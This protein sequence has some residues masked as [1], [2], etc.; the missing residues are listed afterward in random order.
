[1]VTS[2]EYNYSGDLEVTMEEILGCLGGEEYPEFE[3]V[4]GVCQAILDEP[5]KFVGSYALISAAQLSALRTKIGNRAQYY[6]T[7]KGD[8]DASLIIRRR[9]DLLMSMYASLEENINTLKLL[10]RVES[11]MVNWT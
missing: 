6:K 11:R 5:S 2:Q 7:A 4:M 9:K 3:K 8:K 10:G 1:M